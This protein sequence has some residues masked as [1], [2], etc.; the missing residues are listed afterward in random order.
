MRGHPFESR[1]PQ[2]ISPYR[3]AGQKWGQTTHPLSPYASARIHSSPV[4]PT[5]K[6]TPVSRAVPPVMTVEVLVAASPI[7]IHG[8]FPIMGSPAAVMKPTVFRQALPVKVGVSVIIA[9]MMASRINCRY[10]DSRV[11]ITIGRPIKAL[12][13]RNPKRETQG[14]VSRSGGRR[15]Q[16]QKGTN[17]NQ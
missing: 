9:I 12:G 3:S 15:R 8:I 7:M 5:A 2:I 11:D 13:H 1:V 14:Q 16:I 4:M 10:N 6:A 17:S